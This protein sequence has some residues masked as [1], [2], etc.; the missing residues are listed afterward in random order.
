LRVYLSFVTSGPS[1]F[2]S[3]IFLSNVR[4]RGL[5]AHMTKAA[6]E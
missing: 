4:Q 2:E 6:N 1:Y 5:L 3:P